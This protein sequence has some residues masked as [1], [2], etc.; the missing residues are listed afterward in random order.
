LFPRKCTNVEVIDL[1]IMV[2]WSIGFIANRHRIPP[3]NQLVSATVLAY[4]LDD[5]RIPLQGFSN[6]GT[7]RQSRMKGCWA[8]SKNPDGALSASI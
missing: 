3:P 5:L 2:L 7:C 6:W 1:R 4:H 8:P